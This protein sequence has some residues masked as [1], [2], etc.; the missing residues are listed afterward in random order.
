MK[1]CALGFQLR[2]A[3]D[4]TRPWDARRKATYLLREDVVA[5][6]SV[7]VSVWPESQN[8]KLHFEL[9]SNYSAADFSAPNGLNLFNLRSASLA[10][11][12]SLFDD[13]VL[14]AI[15][16]S[17][18]VGAQLKMMHFIEDLIVDICELEKKGWTC[19][20]F[21]VTDYRLKS[22]LMNCGYTGDEKKQLSEQYKRDLN[23]FGLFMTNEVAADF[24]S[25]CDSRA[26]THSPF[27]VCGIWVNGE[28]ERA[29]VE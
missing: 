3:P 25:R 8:E 5:P 12:R 24:S 2:V 15:S 6:L 4:G 7:D 10:S 14:M 27:I 20:G 13:S 17:S 16:V 22:G 21:D 1:I 18:D 19:L 26:S 28:L 23:R 9:F 29:S 11:H